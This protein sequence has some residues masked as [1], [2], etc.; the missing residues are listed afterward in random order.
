MVHADFLITIGPDTPRLTLSKTIVAPHAAVATE[1]PLATL[2]AYDALKKG[3]NAFDAAVAASLVLGVTF[4]PAGGLGG[5][6]FGMFYES[7]T[8]R[9]HCLNAS[10]WAPSGLTLDLVKSRTNG[11]MPTYGP[12]TCVVPGMVAGVWE[13][14]RKLGT[15]EFSDLVRPAADYASQGF[16]AGEG[17]CRAVEGAYS[18][19]SPEARAVFSPSGK[20]T[21]PGESI[22]QP[23][24]AKLLEAISQ[25]GASAFY[26]GWPAERISRTLTDLGVPCT[27]EDFHDF[28]P[29]WVEPITLDYRGT[30]VYEVPPNSM[31]ATSLLMLSILSET[32]LSKFG[33][34]SSDRIRVT[35]DAALVAYAKR[36]EALG[37]PRFS[38]VDIK[39]FIGTRGRVGPLPPKVRSTDTT[40]FS[41]VDSE[42]NVVSGIQSL[43]HHLGSRVF[44][45]EC[46]IALN[47]RAAGFST[48]GPNVVAPRK[49]PLHTLSSLILERDGRPYLA[50]GASGADYRPMQHVLFVTNAVDYSMAAD[51]SV[52]HPRFLWTGGRT[53]IVEDGYQNASNSGYEVQ[54]LPMPGRTGVC[55]AVEVGDTYR[56]AVCDIRGDGIPAGF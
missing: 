15:T 49:R 39:Q 2:A 50:I 54:K 34:L 41:V 1:Q 32:D 30:R 45:P 35:A 53:L 5:D 12:L 46:G 43:F 42:G 10:G 23:A 24:L 36:D 29:E 20:P 55:Q 48:A 3:G 51:K 6:F 8:G 21:T 31:G 19:L 38:R 47:N 7:K 27:A 14:H 26:S 44:V 52:A 40:A 4:H 22:R 33:A 37:D 25:G 13:T 56:M 9:V 17:F 16:P 11:Q 28:K 18:D